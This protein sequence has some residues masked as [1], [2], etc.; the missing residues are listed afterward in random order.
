V[1]V[2]ATPTTDW[3]KATPAPAA[4][5]EIT[6][7]TVNYEAGTLLK[8]SGPGVFYV[9]EA[10]T[11]RHIFDWDTFLAFGFAPEDIVEVDDEALE[12]LTLVGELTRLVA[13][14]KENL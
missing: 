14:E 6:A 8:G 11:R 13:D 4:T 9:T 12:E 2:T 3:V 7:A 10:G 1:V 5:A